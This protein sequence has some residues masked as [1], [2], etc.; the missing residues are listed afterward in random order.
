MKIFDRFLNW[1]KGI[2][3]YKLA[4]PAA[5]VVVIPEPIP[6]VEVSHQPG[7][8]CPECGTRIPIAI[9]TLLQQIPVIC[10]G[11]Q[12]VLN[13]DAQQS[14]GA[15]SALQTLQDGLTAAGKTA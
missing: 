3:N 5:A 7:L 9:T 11:C 8:L 2:F 10:H 6:V 12:L 13:I 1:L 14:H 4:A 15:L